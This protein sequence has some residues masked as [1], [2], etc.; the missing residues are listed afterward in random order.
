MLISVVTDGSELSNYS[1]I[2]MLNSAAKRWDSEVL[3]FYITL[4]RKEEVEK[5]QKRVLERAKGMDVKNHF[6][7]D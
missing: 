5:Y 1:V 4:G 7:S 2:K 3:I 6:S